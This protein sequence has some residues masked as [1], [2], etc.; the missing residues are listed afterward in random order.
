MSVTI[1]TAREARSGAA[2]TGGN[3]AVG[4]ATGNFVISG[5]AEPLSGSRFWPSVGQCS[6]IPDGMESRNLFP[7]IP[8][9]NGGVGLPNR[10]G[11]RRTHGDDI[12]VPPSLPAA[13]A[14]PL[15]GLVEVGPVV[16]LVFPRLRMRQ[17]PCGAADR[18]LPC[19]VLDHSIE[20]RNAYP[21]ERF[22]CG[23]LASPFFRTSR[24]YKNLMKSGTFCQ[25]VGRLWGMA[26][27]LQM[28]PTLLVDGWTDFPLHGGVTC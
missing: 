8:V 11:S 22:D 14:L 17:S 20:L 26:H 25:E 1:R 5:M 12:G 19:A 13:P 27:P 3:S 16:V 9:P 10:D 6:F 2:L 7:A 23:S 15:Q 28:R 4:V 21:D 24:H 18:A